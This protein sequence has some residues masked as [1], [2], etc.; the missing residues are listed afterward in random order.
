MAK[1]TK[2]IEINVNAATA[3]D[4]IAQLQQKI[5]T[6]TTSQKANKKA[7]EDERI[8]YASN[9]AQLREYRKQLNSLV[10]ET[11]NEMRAGAQ[12]LGY[13]QQLEA[14]VSNLEKA[15]YRLS[16]AELEGTKGATILK[17][18]K[19]QRAELQNAQAAYG[20]YTMNVGNYASATNMLAI[21]L[22]QVMKE[23]P[24][25]AISARIGIMSLTN[26]LPMLAEA[27]KAVRV[28]QK[29]MIAEGKAVPS[30]FSLI[31]KSIFGLTGVMSIAMVL[32]QVFSDDIINAA[33]SLFGFGKEAEEAERKQ[34]A[35]NRSIERNKLLLLESA[36]I[37]N[38]YATNHADRVK[39]ILDAEKKAW[40][41]G[42]GRELDALRR[43][44]SVGIKF[45]KERLAE[46][47]KME[48][49]YFEKNAK[50]ESDYRIAKER[51]KVEADEKAK[52]DAEK[53]QL[54]ND[55][56]TKER[57][58]KEYEAFKLN[59]ELKLA[60][61][62][63][64]LKVI[65]ELE[66]SFGKESNDARQKRL[67]DFITASAKSL[68]T[69]NKQIQDEDDRSI[70]EMIR[71]RQTLLNYESEFANMQVA[72]AEMRGEETYNKQVE[73][74]QK[75]KEAAV[76]EA[77][78]KGQE[79]YQIEEYY[80][81]LKSN[82]RKEMV[83]SQLSSIAS[84]FGSLSDMMEQDSVASKIAAT[85]QATINTYL[86]ATAAF[87]QTPGGIITKSLAASAA[88]VSGLAS[89]KKI[90][91]VKTDVPKNS[92]ADSAKTK[93]TVTEKFHTGGVAGSTPDSPQ[94]SEEITRTL[95]TTERVLSPQQTSI[96]DS[97][98]AKVSAMGGSNAIV[99]GAAQVT[100]DVD[101]MYVAM[102]KALR[103][104][105]PPVMTWQEFERQQDRQRRL[106]NNAI[107]K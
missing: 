68:E 40:D 17:N 33:K 5:D 104:M 95:L 12:K 19:E 51:D 83:N 20:K 67:I 55:K 9:T 72:I 91:E 35:F 77:K 61:Y 97:L 37:Q 81:S 64:S 88:I 105:P 21:N 22:G 75:E 59:E 80:E 16:K 79:I 57:F 76:F 87:A 28:Q 30:M 82:L 53:K 14:S 48:L 94:R 92:A 107:I 63:N 43:N 24:N 46:L 84:M 18:L 69:Y 60:N 100:S 38:L 89:V 42:Y 39:N 50:L 103:D 70:E 41:E 58:N 36:E 49:E 45:N 56:L 52:K 101:R 26:N 2:I 96:F 44:K 29:A 85:A 10:V 66:D 1:E 98:V 31:S 4:Q 25:F 34:E 93:S 8:A 74:L 32:L 90:W 86:G 62:E 73:A 23:I 6:L 106:K 47:E 3:I 99:S 78:I 65:K 11:A 15:Y 71:N 27:F 102:S 7:T 54:E 13:L